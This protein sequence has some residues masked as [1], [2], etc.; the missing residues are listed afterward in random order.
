[1][2]EN[3]LVPYVPGLHGKHC[4]V[5]VRRFPGAQPANPSFFFLLKNNI[6][7]IHN[8]SRPSV[9]KSRLAIYKMVRIK[10]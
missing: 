9:T 5:E 4:P 2:H 8:K 6:T 1:M 7:I 3:P 10:N